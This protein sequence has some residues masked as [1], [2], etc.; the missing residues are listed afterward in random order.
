[1]PKELHIGDISGCLEIIGDFAESEKELQETFYQWAAVEWD[2]HLHRC[3]SNLDFKT[4]YGLT[5]EE[6]KQ[7]SDRAKMPKSF[8]GKYRKVGNYYKISYD[9]RFLWHKAQPNTRDFLNDAYRKKKLYKVKCNICGRMFYMDAMSFQCVAWS[10]CVGAECLATTIEKVDVD[11]TKSLYEWNTP[12]IALQIVDHRLAQVDAALDNS[13]TYYGDGQEGGLRIAYIS[14]LHLHHHK[15]YYDD[16]E[17]Q[18]IEDIVGK[19]KHSLEQMNIGQYNRIYAIFFGGDISETPELTVQFLEKFR[20]EVSIPIYFVLGNHE[21]IEFSDV[22]SCVSFY[23]EELQKLQ[24]T[25]LH[26]EY[27]ECSRAGEKF[28]IFGGTGFAKYDEKWNAESIVCCPNFTRE[29]EI[30][31]TTLF[32]TAYQSVLQLAKEQ[33]ICL[34]CLSHYPV[35]ACLNHAYDKEVIYFTGHN[36][37]NEYIRQEDKVLYADNQV[38]YE[39]NNIAFKEATTGLITNPYREMTDGLYQTTVEDYLKFNRYLGEYVGDGT[40]L[41]QRCRNGMLYVV[42]R[43]G[44]YGFFIISTK[45]DSKGISIVNGGMTRK[46]TSS[47]EISW[48]CENFDI[49]VSKYLQLLLPLRK[50]QEELSR[51]LKELGLDGTIHGLIVDIDF[52]H[53]IAL[54]PID[55]TMNFYY[56]S[57]FGMKRDLHSFHEVLQSLEYFN[58]WISEKDLKLIQQKYEVKANAKGYLLGPASNYNLLETENS[59]IEET[60]KRAEHLVSRKEGMYGV[61]RKVNP[62]QRLFSG[63]VLRDFDLRLTE[64]TQQAAHRKKLY[65]G[66]V[67]RLDGVRYQIVED[68]GVDIIIAEELQ[69]G[70]RTKGNAIRLSGN[71]KRFAIE[72]LK[73]KLKKGSSDTH[74]LD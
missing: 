48:I 16:D 46:L 44:Y 25:L 50:A 70:S 56:A 73:S 58:P 28:M 69:K 31:E 10:S 5:K 8:V 32:E 2:N 19:L 22:K 49:V 59:T 21:Y 15:K 51:E 65:E 45:R 9:N 43:K 42:K 39:N 55:G 53:H 24:I 6:S 29:D 40:L 20:A 41:Y 61:S 62:L 38:G 63:R 67:F 64:T 37:N 13:L 26:N 18:M 12:E 3:D 74:W 36:H 35:S 11:Y 34:L 57:V 72:E 47:M 30:R 33:N 17:E 23:R 66:R 27:V 68:K 1:M 7:F 60:T 14:D 52:Y 71:Q 4:H 54:N